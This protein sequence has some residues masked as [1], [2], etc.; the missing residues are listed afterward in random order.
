L[1]LANSNKTFFSAIAIHFLIAVLLY[2][3]LYWVGEI[4]VLPNSENI[5]AWD[6]INYYNIQHQGYIDFELPTSNIPFFPLV[7]LIWRWLGLTPVGAV[8]LNVLFF[9][10]GLNLL[11]RQFK[12]SFQT[13]LL[14]FSI[15]SIFFLCIPYAEALFFLSTTFVVLGLE[16]NKNG[17]VCLGLFIASMTRPSMLFFFPVILFVEI[18]NLKSWKWDEIKNALGRIILFFLSAL[19]GLAMVMMIQYNAT[20]DWL[21]FFHMRERNGLQ[22]PVFPLTTWRGAKMLWLDGFAFAVAFASFLYAAFIVFKKM[23]P[24]KAEI[25][26]PPKSV[27]FSLAFLSM[28]MVHILFFNDKDPIS[29]TSTLFGLN[30]FVFATSS[31]IIIFAYFKDRFDFSLKTNR[32]MF[33]G[34]FIL[35][36]AMLGIFHPSNQP[37]YLRPM[38]YLL[39]IASFLFY[40]KRVLYFWILVYGMNAVT[41]VLLFDK[42][43]RGFWVG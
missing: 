41:Q 2:L 33:W 19:I 13:L 31:F 37:E 4:K 6:A 7:A 27:L 10:F 9:V 25:T 38:V 15:P 3:G 21:A 16:K 8:V 43:L 22:F 39:I 42:F 18:M 29:G 36:L 5:V 28:T 11:H 17:L 30:R 24:S 34:Y 35:I 26:Y 1:N 14:F 32:R 40:Q 20:G 12:F 23:I